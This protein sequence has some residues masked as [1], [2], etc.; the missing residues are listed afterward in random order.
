MPGFEDDIDNEAL[1]GV[2]GHDG[3]C[4]RFSHDLSREALEF[5]L[6]NCL[7]TLNRKSFFVRNMSFT[8]MSFASLPLFDPQ[9]Q[10]ITAHSRLSCF[11]SATPPLIMPL[12]RG[13][14]NQDHL[15]Y[16]PP[17]RVSLCNSL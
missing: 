14:L 11:F 3:H 8:T 9:P 6:H 15:T 1:E 13:F 10:T 2:F 5:H 7:L 4:G 17:T 16:S 12:A